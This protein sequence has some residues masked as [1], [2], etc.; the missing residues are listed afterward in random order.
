MHNSTYSYY[1]G[2]GGSGGLCERMRVM[3]TRQLSRVVSHFKAL[4]TKRGERETV[5]A[6][7]LVIW[8]LGLVDFAGGNP[9]GSVPKP[10]SDHKNP[11]RNTFS[12]GRAVMERGSHKLK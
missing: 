4:E 10:P 6:A 5:V 12:P 2:E 3:L 9:S 1:E 7:M 8:G 11:H